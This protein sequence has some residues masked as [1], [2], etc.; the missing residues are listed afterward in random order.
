MSENFFKERTIFFRIDSIDS[1]S[2]YSQRTASGLEGA[3][4]GGGID[5]F[6]ST[7]D[8]SDAGIGKLASEFTSRLHSI[9]TCQSRTNQSNSV[10]ILGQNFPFDIK[11]K[12]RVCDF[13]QQGGV[14]LILEKYNVASRRVNFFQLLADIN[15]LLPSGNRMSDTGAN[16]GRLA[17]K[18]FRSGKNLFCR[19]KC[20]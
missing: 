14:F 17:E 7:T 9:K 1:V 3:L 4:M 13:F 11:K 15:L 5:A 10:M 20:F 8:N 19:T 12:G 16:T 2:Q 18:I 6:G